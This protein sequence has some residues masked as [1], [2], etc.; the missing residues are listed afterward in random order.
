MKRKLRIVDWKNDFPNIFI[1]MIKIQCTCDFC[2]QSF[3]REKKQF[4]K[5]R[6]NIFCNNECKR[7]Y[8][9]KT[10]TTECGQC[11]KIIF[12]KFCEYKAS[13]SGFAFCN[14]SCSA[15]YN[16][17]HKT[18][19]IRVSKLEIFLQE[20]LIKDYPQL[21]IDFNKKDA[22]NSELDIYVPSLKLAFE[23]NGIFHYE[24]IYGADKLTQIK[25]NDN[26]K[27]QACLEQNIELCIIDTSSFSYFKIDKAMK[28]YNIII[29]FINLKLAEQGLNLHTAH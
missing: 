4:Y 23:L 24:P 20:Q 19:G 17:T 3:L 28:Y 1:R 16:N 25:N 15:T 9:N 2:N 12:K 14:H 11:K 7:Q 13:K 6:K 22:I 27:M 18:K 8:F 26:R 10:I 29:N 5:K 21:K